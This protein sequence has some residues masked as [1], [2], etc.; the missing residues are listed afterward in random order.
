[1]AILTKAIY[2]LNVIPIKLPMTFFTELEQIIQKFTWNHKRPRIATAILRKKNQSRRH[3]SP[4]LQTILQNY[5]N[6]NSACFL[7]LFY[8]FYLFI[9]LLFFGCVG[10][11][12][13]HAGFSLVVTSR[14]YS[15]L[16]CAGFSLWWLLL[17]GAQALGVQVSVV[18]AHGL[19]SCGSRALECKL[20][21]RGTWA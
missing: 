2:R 4:R 19:C 15:S 6:Q 21:S 11:L 7:N 10:S 1:M 18:V 12:L 5:S 14:G 3:N 9:Y 8:Y 13:L 16:W 17:L 20:S